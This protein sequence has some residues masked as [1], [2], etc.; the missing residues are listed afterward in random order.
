MNYKTQDFAEESKKLTG[1]KGIDVIIDFVGQR[2]WDKNITSLAFD[3]RMTMLGLLSGKVSLSFTL[4]LMYITFSDMLR[5][6]HHGSR[7]VL[8]INMVVNLIRVYVYR[9][10]SHQV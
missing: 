7:R 6:V 9:R 2:H 8:S 10:R 5:T 1:G 4:S 3:G